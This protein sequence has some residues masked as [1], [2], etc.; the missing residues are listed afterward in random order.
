MPRP[1]TLPDSLCAFIRS[2]DK[3]PAVTIPA[4]NATGPETDNASDTTSPP[5]YPPPPA[6]MAA[7]DAYISHVMACKQC[8]TSGLRIPRHCAT[9]ERLRRELDAQPWDSG[10]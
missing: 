5:A 8:V 2:L 4:R 6:W 3:P 1:V 9:G 10:P 7:R